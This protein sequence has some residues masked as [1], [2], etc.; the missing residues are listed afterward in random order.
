M[1]RDVAVF[2]IDL[3]PAVAFMR[4][5]GRA[6]VHVTA[7]SASGLDAGR[8]SRFHD[9]LRRC[10]PVR[11]TDEFID[12]L[13]DRLREGA[14]DL[15]APTS[16]YIAFCVA[17]A[18]AKIGGDLDVGHPDAE[19]VRTCLFKHQF[20]VA[21][22]HVGLPTPPTA[23]PT[24]LEDALAAA[25]D[26]G[27][28][29]VLKPRSDVGIGTTRGKV[30]QQ[31]D[32]LVKQFRPYAIG[33][34]QT[35]VQRHDP[36]LAFPLV[37]RY[38][39]LGSVEVISITGCI[40]RD[41]EAVGVGHSR[42]VSQSPRRLGV[43]TMFEPLPAQPFTE[44][45]VHA[46]RSILG[47]GLFELE[48]LV[49]KRTGEHWGL[50]LNPRAYG[51]IALDIALGRDLPVLWYRA[52]TGEDVPV[53]P[54]CA[55]RPQYWH[56]AV[57]S[58]VG[59]GVRFLRGPAL[60]GD[61]RTRRRTDVRAERQRDVPV[62]GSGSRA[63]VRTRPLPPP[64]SDDPAV[65]H[66]RRSARH[67]RL[68][69]PCR[70]A[71]RTVIGAARSRL[72]GIAK[73]HVAPVV[74]RRQPV[75][76]DLLPATWGL[77]VGAAGT[78]VSGSVDL[79]ELARRHGTP[80]HVVRADRLDANAAAAQRSG[81]AEI[82][83]SYKT[84]P[85]PAVLRR[86]H[87]GGIGAEVISPYELWLALRLGVPPDRIV[88]NGPAKSPESIRVA[89]SS[90]VLAVNAN[91]VSEAGLI[92][93]IAEEEG[94][95]VN[96]GLRLAVPGV[97]GGQFGIATVAAAAGAVRAALG[98]SAR[99]P[100]RDPRP[101]WRDD[102]RRVGRGG[103][104]GVGA[105]PLRRAAGGDRVVARTARPRRQPGLPDRRRPADPP[106][107]AQPRPRDRSAAARPGCRDHGG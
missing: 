14:I 57:T 39:D 89:I 81:R 24:T 74:A 87:A 63:E 104:C 96:L 1:S 51:Q 102:A 23:M 10:P 16:D 83:S 35:S 82:F 28:P 100:R 75:R 71:H 95:T 86:L 50:D 7:M 55:R 12:W 103:P 45:A 49:D 15:I 38:F 31:P 66:R 27:Y 25:A 94:R 43:G 93:R 101:P 3:P 107:P 77:A 79:V 72:A 59:F 32:E 56:D 54:P 91:T 18:A 65:P 90:G 22:E 6:G 99:H 85:V 60:P 58:Y 64:A 70:A 53:S 19:G 80:L 8:W 98:F 52:V 44:R 26:I 33:A 11:A 37:Q 105:R 20:S 97:W 5:L 21:M 106:V 61:R 34:G 69:R 17:E 2:D 47:S 92:G 67:R 73:R 9:E 13:A 68:G 36:E 78:L 4:S 30:V 84:N 48:V 41:G 76:T 42:K 62:V 46:V 40:D 88:Y 29:V